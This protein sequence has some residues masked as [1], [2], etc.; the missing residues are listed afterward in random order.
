MLSE[1]QIRGLN[2]DESAYLSQL[3][4]AEYKRERVLQREADALIGELKRNQEI[5]WKRISE[6]SNFGHSTQ[7]KYFEP[8]LFKIV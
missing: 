1:N 6:S 8:N 3:S 4:Q 2:E 5:I 7:K